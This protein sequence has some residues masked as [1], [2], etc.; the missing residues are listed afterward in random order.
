MIFVS[1]QDDLIHFLIILLSFDI[2]EILFIF[3]LEIKNERY[4]PFCHQCGHELKENMKFCP[5][6][7]TPQVSQETIQDAQLLP[8]TDSVE[9]KK[10]TYSQEVTIRHIP[11][12]PNPQWRN[13]NIALFITLIGFVSAVAPFITE[14][15]IM[16]YGGAMIMIGLLVGITAFITYF[17]FRKRAKILDEIIQGKDILLHWVFDDA[18]WKKHNEEELANRKSQNKATLIM[19]AVIMVLVTGGLVIATGADEG[20]LITAGIMVGVFL[21]VAIAAYVGTYSPY[22]KAQKHKGEAILNPQGL[23]IGGAFHS[24]K[25]FG[26]RLENFSYLPQKATLEIIYSAKARHQRQFFTVRVPVPKGEEARALAVVQF[27]SNQLV[28]KKT[29]IEEEVPDLSDD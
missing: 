15:D 18:T 24:W 21:L 16:K 8:F 23:W 13:A 19:I 14:I 10:E 25:G 1:I 20:S 4:M 28:A 17:I 7:G 22:K 12:I 9:D 29:E 6:C 2:K 27:F 11:N 3:S 5:N 26:T